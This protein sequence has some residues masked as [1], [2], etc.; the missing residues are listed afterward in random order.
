MKRNIILT[1]FLGLALPLF[2]SANGSHGL[3][4]EDVLGEIMSS[5][6]VGEVTS[7]SCQEIT[8]EQF[9]ELGE[10]V[11][12]I[13]HPDEQQHE[14]MDQ[15]MGGE[16]SESL[17]AMHVAMGQNYLGCGTGV[18]GGGVMGGTD[19]MSMV[20]G[21]MMDNMMG[22]FGNWGWLGLI[23]MILLWILVI[24]GIIALIKW[25]VDQIRE[26]K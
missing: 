17:K 15:M 7:I 22:N 12:S 24:V 19:M 14:L 13:I 11:M 6:N 2:I 3:S 16:G 10:A 5:Q 8:D 26:K 1:I 4:V 20:G 9:E 23:L 18:M 21:G 25:L